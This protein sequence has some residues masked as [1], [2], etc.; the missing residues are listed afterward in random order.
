MQISIFIDFSPSQTINDVHEISREGHEI[1]TFATPLRKRNT[2]ISLLNRC[3]CCCFRFF[4]CTIFYLFDTDS[5]IILLLLLY[6]TF[7]AE[8]DFSPS[9]PWCISHSFGHFVSLILCISFG[10]EIDGA[11]CIGSFVCSSILLESWGNKTTYMP[12]INASNKN[13]NPYL[14]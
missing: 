12:H 10:V 5:M 2:I 4:L 14:A 1:R 6:T 11:D 3:C 7:G 8:F 13:I 9:S